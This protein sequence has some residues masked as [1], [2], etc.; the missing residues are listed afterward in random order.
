MFSV[1]LPEYEKSVLKSFNG[2]DPDKFV[3]TD[4]TDQDMLPMLTSL[5]NLTNACINNS[6]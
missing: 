3:F 5:V 4:P 1:T 6:S 2:D